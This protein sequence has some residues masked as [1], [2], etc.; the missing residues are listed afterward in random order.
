MTVV[1]GIHFLR[2]VKLSTAKKRAWAAVSKYLRHSQAIDGY[3]EC[4]TCETQKRPE[5]MQMGHGIQGRGNAILFECDHIRPQCPSCN[6]WQGGRLDVFI[7]KLLDEIGRSRY[8][9]L[10]DMKGKTRKFTVDELLEIEKEYKQKLKDL[11][12]S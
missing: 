1:R 6:I 8:D 7:P 12:D 9:E 4:Y 11:E 5:E 3:L 2:K 10:L